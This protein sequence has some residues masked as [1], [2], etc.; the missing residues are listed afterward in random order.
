VSD[1]RE[2]RYSVPEPMLERED[3]GVDRKATQYDGAPLRAA[4]VPTQVQ[5]TLLVY[6]RVRYRLPR[7]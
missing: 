7:R 3:E 4:F 2:G 1:P 6:M 5:Q